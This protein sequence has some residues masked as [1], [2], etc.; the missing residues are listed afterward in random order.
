MLGLFLIIV[1]CKGV[2]FILFVELIE[3]LYFIRMLVVLSL[4]VVIILCMI[5]VLVFIELD[6]FILVLY[7]M[8]YFVVF[9]LLWRKV[10]CRGVV[11]LLSWIFILMF[12][13]NIIFSIV[14]RCYLV[15]KWRVVVSSE[16]MVVFKSGRNFLYLLSIFWIFFMFL[17]VMVFINLLVVFFK[18]LKFFILN[19]I[20]FYLIIFFFWIYFLRV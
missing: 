14:W 7:F 2:R 13:F 4:F 9:R 5:L 6:L 1:R 20:F 18:S 8:K 16:V 10:V 12:G 11:L 17:R 15:M 19:V 3:V